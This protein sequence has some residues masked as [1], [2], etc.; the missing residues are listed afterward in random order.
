MLNEDDINL[1]ET[2]EEARVGSVPSSIFYI[3]N[4]ISASE[5]E[6]LLN[7]V[8]FHHQRMA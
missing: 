2:L 5:E 1:P 7:K 8:R 4:F 6:V 3:P